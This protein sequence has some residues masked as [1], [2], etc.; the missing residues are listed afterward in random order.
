MWTIVDADEGEILTQSSHQ[1]YDQ[2]I[3]WANEHGME[4]ADELGNRNPDGPAR[5]GNQLFFIYSE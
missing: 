1:T 3:Q 4:P 5:D 2:A